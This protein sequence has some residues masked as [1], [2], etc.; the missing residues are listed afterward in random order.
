MS[1]MNAPTSP[2]F[3]S[4]VGSLGKPYYERSGVAL[5]CGDCIDLIARLDAG[6]ADLIVTSP[7]YNIGKEYESVRPLTD[8]LTWCSRWLSL[9]HRVA[10]PHSSLWLNLGY[11]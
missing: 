11:F 3:D 8:Y 1:S 6:T 4:M 9:L 7:P 2:K 5:Y 10:S